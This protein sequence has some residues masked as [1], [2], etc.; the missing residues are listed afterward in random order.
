MPKRASYADL[1]FFRGFSTEL[2]PWADTF[3]IVVTV[4]F[5]SKTAVGMCTFKQ[6]SSFNGRLSNILVTGVVVLLE[7]DGFSSMA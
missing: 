2:V 4:S 1:G 7:V 5:L 3:T 6:G